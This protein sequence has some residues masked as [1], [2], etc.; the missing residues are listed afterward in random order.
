MESTISSSMNSR[1]SGDRNWSLSASTA[2]I[3]ASWR[4]RRVMALVADRNGR[5]ESPKAAGNH[6]C[7]QAD[8][9]CRSST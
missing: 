8:E 4:M 5:V 2:R 7:S 9:A 1:R 3:S 6:S